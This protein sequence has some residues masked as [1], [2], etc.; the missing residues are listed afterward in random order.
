MHAECAHV[1]VHPSLGFFL[2]PPTYTFSPQCNTYWCITRES[3]DTTM[4]RGTLKV[5][6]YIYVAV[7]ATIAL[8]FARCAD[9]SFLQL[10]ATGLIIGSTLAQ[11]TIAF[12]FQTETTTDQA[13][14]SFHFV[15]LI[16]C[17]SLGR[18]HSPQTRKLAARMCNGITET[19]HGTA[20]FVHLCASARLI[21]MCLYKLTFMLLRLVVGYCRVVFRQPEHKN[22]Y[23]V[24][25][26][27][28]HLQAIHNC[29]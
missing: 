15:S 29:F 13:C 10:F 28:M 22:T 14:N 23:A 6:E 5:D 4:L 21:P 11:S 25:A 16:I 18:C 3:R 26:V 8:Q 19:C 24:I 27:D 20:V 1:F 7:D 17:P 2:Q 12:F 9:G